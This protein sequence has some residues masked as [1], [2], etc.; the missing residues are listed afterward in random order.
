MFA[1]CELKSNRPDE[2]FHLGNQLGMNSRIVIFVHHF[3]VGAKGNR[4]FDG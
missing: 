2:A 1:K 4:V 3:W